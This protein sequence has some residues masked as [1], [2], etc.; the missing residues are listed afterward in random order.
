MQPGK[1]SGICEKT[2]WSALGP[3][4][5][6]PMATITEG[7]EGMVVRRGVFD[8]MVGTVMIIFG[9]PEAAAPLI[10]CA[11]SVAILSSRPSP[12]SWGLVTKSNA[13]KAKARKVIEALASVWA[14]TT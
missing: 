3:P 13:P 1:F 12:A 14:L 4:V 2:Y 5:E 8:L 9:G 6:M 11:S 7:P 10:F